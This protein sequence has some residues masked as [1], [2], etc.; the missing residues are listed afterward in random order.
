MKKKTPEENAE[1]EDRTNST[2]LF[3]LA[4]W[5]APGLDDTRLS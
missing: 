2:G 4:D 1:N 3:N 5:P